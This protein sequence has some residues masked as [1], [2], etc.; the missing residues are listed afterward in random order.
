MTNRLIAAEDERVEEMI[1]RGEK[2][3]YRAVVALRDCSDLQSSLDLESR[4][5]CGQLT[6]LKAS[7]A[8]QESLSSNDGTS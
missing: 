5:H 4:V 1:L 3:N 8:P 7:H 2:A 6:D